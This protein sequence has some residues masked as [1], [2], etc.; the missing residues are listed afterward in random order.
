M[1]AY[2]A[3]RETVRYVACSLVAASFRKRQSS[4]GTD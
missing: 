3:G 4:V 2:N 1:A